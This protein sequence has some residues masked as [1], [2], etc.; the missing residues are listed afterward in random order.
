[1]IPF[2]LQKELVDDRGRSLAAHPHRSAWPARLEPQIARPDRDP[3]PASI[4]LA[5][6]AFL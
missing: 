4:L 5:A 3:S 6:V 2:G 1:M